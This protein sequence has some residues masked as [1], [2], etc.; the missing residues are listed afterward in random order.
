MSMAL[1]P[2]PRMGRRFVLGSLG[3]LGLAACTP[4]VG[5]TGQPAGGNALAA[6]L[7]ADPRFS[8]FVW[9]IQEEGMWLTLRASPKQYTIFAPI[10]GAYDK[11]P[12]GWKADTYPSPGTVGGFDNR[13]RVIGLLRM[14]FV[15]GVFPLSAFAG[16]IQPVLTLAGTEFFADG[17]QPG[18]LT[19]LLKP[20][21]ETGIGFPDPR[22]TQQVANVILPPIETA[23][24]IIYPVDTILIT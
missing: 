3:M 21:M 13:A 9:V 18:K 24:G 8:T 17:T 4:A 11:L 20:N 14:H 7:E 6:A 15:A 22:L 23:G 12:P 10:N 5:P 16:R 19:L 1:H 2:G